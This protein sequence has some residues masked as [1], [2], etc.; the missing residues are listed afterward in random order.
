MAIA[1]SL[2]STDSCYWSPVKTV[3]VWPS[4]HA[5]LL[6]IR[7]VTRRVLQ[8]RYSSTRLRGLSV[9][10]VALL[11]AGILATSWATRG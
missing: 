3:A 9:A 10:A 2:F 1:D 6:S 11:T 5:R 8:G 4:Q 7:S